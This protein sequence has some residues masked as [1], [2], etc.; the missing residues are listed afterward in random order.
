MCL[1]VPCLKIKWENAVKLEACRVCLWMVK[2]CTREVG[3]WR[4]DRGGSAQENVRMVDICRCG[5]DGESQGTK[6]EMLS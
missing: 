4:H 3:R 6:D 1:A 2:V 5:S